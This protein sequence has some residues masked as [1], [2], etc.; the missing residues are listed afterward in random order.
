MQ[1]PITLR[2]RTSLLIILLANWTLLITGG[3]GHSLWIDEWFTVQNVASPWAAVLP[4]L[5][6]EERRPPLYWITLKAWSEL[7]GHS[8][9]ALRL[10]SIACAA[11]AIA[12]VWR[13]GRRLLGD[14]AAVIAAAMF[15][16][17]PF[18]LL[19]GSMVRSYMLFAALT[20]LS[21][22][23]WQKY[24]QRSTMRTWALY[25]VSLALL[26]YT[27]YGAVAVLGSHGAWWLGRLVLRRDRRA[28]FGIGAL[29]A[30]TLAF[31]PWATV[32]IG[33]SARSIGGLA[34]DLASSPLGTLLKIGM[35]FVSLGAGETLYPWTPL[36]V[37]GVASFN[38]AAAF[39]IRRLWRTDRTTSTFVMLWI[40]V[41]LTFTATLLS[42]VAVDITFLN[43]T[44]RAPHL[45]A[46]FA[47]L[48][49]CGAA[50]LSSRTRAVLL[51]AIA[52][53]WGAG[54]VNYY[55]MQEYHNPIYAVP[56][57]DVA[58]R[59]RAAPADA[60]LIAESDTLVP[61]YYRSA[62]GAATLLEVQP[63]D[64]LSDIQSRIERDAPPQV[65][66]A[67]FGR[68]RT[69]VGF[70]TP[71]LDQWLQQ[72]G[73]REVRREEHGPV[74][75]SYRWIKARLLGRD[76]Y[77]HKLTVQVFER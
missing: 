28:W 20:V 30:A 54:Y 44:S 4:K 8:E 16:L 6:A 59:M 75:D 14:R 12:L 23:A 24:V 31:A 3:V 39:G 33:Q 58:V 48:A 49:G 35:P 2:T 32:L 42:L 7:A 27:D 73:Y 13:F 55:A 41:T 72:R 56:T 37:V 22:I 10:L 65:H 17:T 43:A 60:L 74:G 26:L 50:A 18:V 40:A 21:A 11:A 45:A 64:A 63:N 57:R 71:T 76:P 70:D 5:I 38:I 68:D 34:A 36:G 46:A 52:V 66:I 69:S 61:Y 53:V 9:F 51:T 77:S 15:G 47:L 67:W 25:V 1:S 62:P 19:Y 29:A